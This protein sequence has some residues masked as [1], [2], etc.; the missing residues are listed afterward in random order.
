M[1]R[2]LKN[3]VEVSVSDASRAGSKAATW[4]RE[5]NAPPLACSSLW[6]LGSQWIGLP[7]Q[8]RIL[9]PGS[10]DSASEPAQELKLEKGQ[11]T[12]PQRETCSFQS[13]LER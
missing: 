6:V 2:Y 5:V 12:T 10:S 4:K 7:L 3:V 1:Y 11:S 8:I 13:H 9:G